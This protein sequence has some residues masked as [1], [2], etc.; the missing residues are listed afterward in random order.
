M[1]TKKMTLGDLQTLRG[2]VASTEK[3]K[4]LSFNVLLNLRTMDKLLEPLSQ[5]ITKGSENFRVEKLDE[6]TKSYEGEKEK[7]Q[8]YLVEQLNKYLNDIPE[9]TE[10]WNKE[11]EVE[12]YQ[13]PLSKLENVEFDI[14]LINRLIG[15]T[16]SE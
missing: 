5:V 1:V 9:V 13:T 12:L 8:S 14:M 4:V 7:L 15:Y 3:Y 11:V 6:L 16:I 10:L 2:V